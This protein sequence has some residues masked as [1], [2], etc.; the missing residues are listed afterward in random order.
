MTDLEMLRKLKGEDGFRKE[1]SSFILR[2]RMKT[3]GVGDVGKELA[4][5]TLQFIK[6]HPA[7]IAGALLGSA[8]AGAYAHAAAKPGP[9]GKSLDQKVLEEAAKAHE[10]STREMREQGREPG[11]AHQLAGATVQGSKPI[12]EVLSRHPRKA[13]LLLAPTGAGI[14]VMLAKTLFK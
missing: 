9:S 6:N 12:A 14:G 5:T 11:F 8:M 10:K 1:A 3:A 4:K 13:A 7:E 2:S